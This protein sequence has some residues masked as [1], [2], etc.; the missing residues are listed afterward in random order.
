[1]LFGLDIAPSDTAS[2]EKGKLYVAAIPGV[3]Y[4]LSTKFAV[5]IGANAG[6]YTDNADSVNL[7]TFNS[8]PTYTTNHQ[9]VVP[10][11]SNIWT[12]GNEYNILGNWVFYKYPQ[13]TFG[14]GGHSSASDAEQ[15]EYRYVQ[16]RET[17]L[18]KI[19]TNVYA[20]IGYALDSRWDITDGGLPGGRISDFERYGGSSNTTASGYTLNVKYDGRQNP[21]N[22]PEGYYASLV[23]R[24]NSP[25][26]GSDGNWQSMILDLRS[27]Y[28]LSDNS[29]NVLAFWS[30]DWFILRGTPSYLDLPASSWD[31]FA[32]QGRGYIQSRFRGR[33]LISFESEYRF[34]ITRNGLFGGVVFANA[35]SVSDWPSNQFTVLHPAVGCG[36]RFKM[37]KHDD[38]NL[39]IDYGFG[40]Q[41]SQGVFVNLGEVF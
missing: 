9:I 25:F 7:S 19:Y 12:S 2:K 11:Q 22:P 10:F 21:I 3:G 33:N 26:F 20:G 6:L 36:I 41:G 31:E 30:Y 18:K 39:A 24:N 23:Y 17:V 14:L 40:L 34:G 4:S 8:D 27:Y 37:N 28:T 1:M 38:T 5:T 15:L 32:N 13:L 29:R 35:Q 16:L